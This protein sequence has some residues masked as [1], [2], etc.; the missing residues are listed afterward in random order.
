M[1]PINIAARI[2][3]ALFGLS[4]IGCAHNMSKSVPAPELAGQPSTVE[5]CRA[6]QVLVV[7]NQSGFPVRVRTYVPSSSSAAAFRGDGWIVQSSSVDTLGRIPEGQRIR[8]HV[9]RPAL[10]SGAL[11][12]TSGI[13]SWCA[14]VSEG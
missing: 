12:P 8:L 9:Q 1:A 14:D 7:D 6:S 5:S 4:L 10:P 2:T 11:Q 3:P 13:R